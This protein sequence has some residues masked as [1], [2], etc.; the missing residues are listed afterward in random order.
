MLSLLIIKTTNKIISDLKNEIFSL[1]INHHRNDYKSLENNIINLLFLVNKLDNA[2]FSRSSS[3]NSTLIDDTCELPNINFNILPI[4]LY[5][6]N[7]DFFTIDN[8]NELIVDVYFMFTDIFDFD[9]LKIDINSFYN[10]IVEISKKYN[11]NPYHNFQHAVTVT[12]FIYLIIKTTQIINILPKYKLFGLL[13]SGLV[14]DIDHP[15]T[16]NMFE[17]NKK[18]ILALQYN[19]NSVLENHHCSTAFYIMQKEDIKLLK[20]LNNNEFSEL[21]STIIECIMATDMKNHTSLINSYNEQTNILLNHKLLCKLIIHGSDLCN[22]LKKYDVY[23]NGIHRLHQE[24]LNQKEKEEKL[25]IQ[26][27]KKI[28]TNNI[29]EIVAGEIN[30]SSKF[31]KPFWTNIVKIFPEL[32]FLLKEHENNINCLLTNLYSISESDSD[33]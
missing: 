15:G 24:M 26:I 6:W 20:N 1:K 13:L 25:S 16:D 5:N 12:H 11:N 2:T 21:R 9:D 10:C 18:S 30:F 17:I 8:K 4:K 7:Y 19:D 27:T 32:H 23:K 3:E 33:K 28:D 31:V 14:H 22:Q 29:N